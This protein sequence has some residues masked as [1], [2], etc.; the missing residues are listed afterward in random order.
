MTT[1]RDI[2]TDA[3]GHLGIGAEGEA[4]SATAAAHGLKELNRM[5]SSWAIDELM[6]YT[7]NRVAFSLVPWQQAYTIG[8]GGNF[9]TTTPIRPGQID[10][11]S[12]L[13]S[14][15]TVELPI[16]IL[17]DE[18]WR[19][20]VVK[21]VPSSFPLSMWSDGNYPLNTIYFWPVPSSSAYSIVLYLWGALTEFADIN[22]SVVL[23]QGYE[24][25][26]VTNLAV[27]LSPSYG[28]QPSPI[29]TSMA[30]E[31]KAKIKA[32]NWTPTYRSVDQTLK[33][34]QNNTGTRSRGYVVD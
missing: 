16:D 26:L 13:L 10:M 5:M 21:T 7:T 31:A 30:G 9:V 11:A 24:D 1:A 27:R 3:L 28:S 34:S 23:P 2:I 20:M 33:G 19:D 14:G 8:V 32:M 6:V 12:V 17:N 29:L 15:A 25:A 22:A 18:Q 4:V